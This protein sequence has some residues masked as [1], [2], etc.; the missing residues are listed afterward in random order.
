M[1]INKNI[2]VWRGDS[3]P[4]TKYH[5]WIKSDGI[6][7][8]FNGSDWTKVLDQIPMAG[9]EIDGLMSKEDKI[10][11][12]ELPDNNSLTESLNNTVKLSELGQPN[13]VATLND[14][15]KI[16]SE[17]LPSYVDDVLEY[18]N[19]LQF[20]IPGETGKI[21]VAL[22]T[23]RTYRWSGS[24]YI[25]IAKAPTPQSSYSGSNK[26]YIWSE[27]GADN[28]HGV[29]VMKNTQ[30]RQT[31]GNLQ[32][33]LGEWCD[34][35]DTGRYRAIDVPR[36]TTDK[37]GAM[38]SV[39]Y[40]RLSNG[41]MYTN[42]YSDHLT[43]VYPNYTSYY[44]KTFNLP[45]ATITQAG[46]MT[47]SDKVQLN[48][49]SKLES[50]LLILR[51]GAKL[52]GSTSPATIYKGVKTSVTFVG[53]FSSTDS[54]LIPKNMSMTKDGYTLN[55]VNNNKTVSYV[56]PMT[57]NNNSLFVDI[58]AIVDP[59]NSGNNITFTA[60]ATV[61]ARY[62]IF[63]GFANTPEE[64]AVDSNKLSARLSANGTYTGTASANGVHYIILVP[65]DI[66]ALNSFTMNATPFVMN[67][68]EKVINNIT[69]KVYTS[70]ATYNTGA[71]VKIVA[72]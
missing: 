48:K 49:V 38:P 20:P 32:L 36:V 14:S 64:I 2:S 55:T 27:S 71:E 51:T 58:T 63:A 21:Y 39:V 10:K 30:F 47:S 42:R 8:I 25:E 19:N 61:N 60:K 53:T 17:Q 31:Y 69:Y 62:P 26:N 12:D 35:S 13:G 52:S 72:V 70:G 33:Q 18:P 28:S 15:G 6:Q 16:S 34:P 22:D 41:Y 68:S 66:N 40:N 29:I 44:S 5:L 9:Q 43:I 57:L 56:L 50:D 59:N 7:Y 1:N 45:A 23:G 37:D 11:L 3:T 46:V 65:S 67:K 4:P 54:N 24:L